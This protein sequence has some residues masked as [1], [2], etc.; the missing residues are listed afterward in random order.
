MIASDP[1][2]H[3]RTRRRAMRHFG[4]PHSPH[5]IP[6]MEVECVRIINGLLDRAKGKTRI[7]VVD[8]FAY[9]LPVA[10]ICK[11]LACHW[12]MSRSS[13]AGSAI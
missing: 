9:P 2:D 5:L 7:D 10:V 6:G 11:V 3:D 4:P 8:D 13:T 12:P 1:P